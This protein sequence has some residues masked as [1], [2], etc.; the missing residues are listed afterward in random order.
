MG[1]AFITLVPLGL[2]AGCI[3]RFDYAPPPSGGTPPHWLVVAKSAAEVW[4]QASAGGGWDR[5]AM[6]TVDNSAGVITLRYHGDPERYVDC[7]SITSYVQNARGKRTYQ[8]P[9]ATASTEYELMTGRE[10]LSIARRMQLEARIA[11]ALTP[12]GSE[13]TRVSATT[14]YVLSRTLLIRDTQ[15]RSQTISHLI[16]FTSDRGEAFPGMIACR[17]TGALEA[18]VLS[19]FA[20]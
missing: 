5:F 8:F 1:R 4:R 7:G 10:I 20:P 16:R 6:E 14:R 2:L 12:I 3:G 17:P 11:V 18:D 13:G 9:A 19:A 15:G